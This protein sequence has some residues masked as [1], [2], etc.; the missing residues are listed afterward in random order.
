M[1]SHSAP[2]FQPFRTATG[3]FVWPAQAGKRLYEGRGAK[4]AGSQLDFVKLPEKGPFL[5]GGRA[6]PKTAGAAF[7]KFMFDMNVLS[8]RTSL[9]TLSDS[10]W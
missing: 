9:S 10:D 7:G 6:G 4:E 5:P 1:C 8:L 3:K 2:P